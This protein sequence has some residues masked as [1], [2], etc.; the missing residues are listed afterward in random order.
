M[1]ESDY[2]KIFRP[3][4]VSGLKRLGSKFD[5]GYV[6][7]HPSL[8]DVDYLVNYGVGYNVDFECDFFRETG[9][10]TLAF[11]PT[12]SDTTKLK[13]FATSFSILRLLSELKYFTPWQF[14]RLTLKNFKITLIEEGLSDKN[15]G[16]YKTLAYHLK[17]YNLLDKKIMLKVD[18]EGA[19]YEVFADDSIYPY[20]EN[21][22][23]LVLEFHDLKNN[24]HQVHAIITKLK[25]T[26]TLIHIHAN[27]HG[28]YFDFNGK[29]VPE[30]IELSYLRNTYIDA[31]I[32]SQAN[33]P[34]PVLDQPSH[35]R[36]PD[37]KLDFF[38]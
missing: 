30:L 4:Y 7:H 20:L 34:I 5:G 16:S 33:Y 32:P 19:E 29:R 3:N 38:K 22:V 27:N 21:A 18:I 15:L 1:Q 25:T 12:L 6:I 8:K 31:A 11:D 26:H 9:A 37:L 14:R 10:P 35:K 28:G 13:K 17:K 24:L 36:K 2:L 23:Q